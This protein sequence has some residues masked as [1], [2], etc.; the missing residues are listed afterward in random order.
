MLRGNKKATP[1]IH[2]V[3]VWR[4]DGRQA[5]M[6]IISPCFRMEK[7]LFVVT[8]TFSSRFIVQ[9]GKTGIT[10]NGEVVV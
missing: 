2:Y 6:L 5:T 1:V 9:L 3:R 7:R 10:E 4:V 8:L